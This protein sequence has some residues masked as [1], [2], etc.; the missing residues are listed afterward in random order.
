MPRPVRVALVGYGLAGKVFH[1]PL[2]RATEGLVLAAVV[3]RGG[4]GARA[5]LPGVTVVPELREVLRDEAIDLVVIATPD[6]LHADQAL[7]ALDA[8]KHVLIDKPFASTLAEAIRV[9][10]RAAQCDRV[11]AVFQNR[12]WDADFLSLQRLIAEGELGDIVQF[13]SHFDRY[14][15]G[16]TDRW[17]ETRGAGVW[18]DLGPHL[19]DQALQLFGVPQA[20]TA[21]L[22]VQR[23]GG[24]APDY[25]HV[26]LRYGGR[27]RVILH[28][29]QL[30]QASGLRFAVHGTRGSYLK[31][32]LDP[33]E[34]QSKAGVT[35]QDPDWGIDT[36]PGALIRA[37]ADGR[38]QECAVRNERGNYPLFYQRLRDAVLGI[39]AN[40]VPAEQALAVMNVLE[41]GRLSAA[42]RREV[43]LHQR[44]GSRPIPVCSNP[45]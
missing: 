11:L 12:R 24:P 34:S 28:I 39:G 32:G 15:P 42:E 17:K 8:G 33:Q 31:H 22:A 35:P 2:I 40:P 7:A 37:G 29:S 1:A 23:T 45:D 4:G 19:V 43:P 27:L 16:V 41:A 10:E 9:A 14:R 30:T 36:Q 3:S 26:L 18:Q 5:D 38:E 44:D 21:D 20:V 6:A 25:A 13:E